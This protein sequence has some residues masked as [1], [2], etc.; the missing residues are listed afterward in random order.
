LFSSSPRTAN[1]LPVIVELG[2]HVAYRSGR[3]LNLV[4]FTNPEIQGELRPA[5]RNPNGPSRT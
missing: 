5:P 2:A 4:R 3:R 1:G